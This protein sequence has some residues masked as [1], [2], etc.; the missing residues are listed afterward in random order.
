MTRSILH[1][2]FTLILATCLG[3]SSEAGPPGPTGP[4]GPV[5]P[6]GEAGPSGSPGGS[7]AVSSLEVGSAGCANGGARLVDAQGTISVVCNGPQ[8]LPGPIGPTG[9]IGA[10]GLIGPTGLTGSP[11]PAGPT[12]AT[13]PT[14]PAGAGGIEQLVSFAGSIQIPIPTGSVYVFFGPTGTVTVTAGQRLT[15]SASVP[16][17][18]TTAN[19][20]VALG[21]CYQSTI[22]G[23]HIVNFVGGSYSDVIVGPLRHAHAAAGTVV[24]SAGTFRVG[25]CGQVKN[26]TIDGAD[27]VNGWVMVTN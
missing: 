11:G 12:G 3:C 24:M 23:S 9:P 22:A 10:T 18:A 1:A 25:A 4:Q 19:T 15:G 7:V 14:G 5:G 26:G 16:I 6:T 27:Y 21:L 8:G 20:M 2:L 17:A 13:G